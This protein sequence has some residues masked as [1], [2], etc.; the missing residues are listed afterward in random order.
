MD[1]DILSIAQ[2]LA[3]PCV[4]CTLLSACAGPLNNER[5]IGD[6]VNARNQFVPPTIGRGD[7]TSQTRGRVIEIDDPRTRPEADANP[8]THASVLSLDRSNWASTRVVVPNDLVAHQPRYTNDWAFDKSTAR[9]RGEYPTAASAMDMPTERGADQ[10]LAEAVLAPLAAG[11]DLALS[12]L[13]AIAARPW[14][15]TRTGLEGYQRAPQNRTF[16]AEGVEPT[17]FG[18]DQ[19]S[20]TDAA[21]AEPG[22]PQDPTPR[23]S[24]RSLDNVNPLTTPAPAPS[25]SLRP[26]TQ[27]KDAATKPALAPK[28]P[29]KKRPKPGDPDDDEP[30]WGA[31]KASD[32]PQPTSPPPAPAPSSSPSPSAAPANPPK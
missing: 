32:A 17:S 30:V 2:R 26:Q 8:E 16:P 22:S 12:P 24:E 14:Q 5:F 27:S 9:N 3:L 23:P 11:A 21:R 20:Q 1:A 31:P 19:P 29:A 10:Q 6:P 7:E 18:S 25:E 4:L 15:R 28:P 13:R